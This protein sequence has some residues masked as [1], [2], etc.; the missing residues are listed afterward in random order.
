MDPMI[1]FWF[2]A[3]SV[4]VQITIAVALYHMAEQRFSNGALWAWIGILFGPLALLVY[5]AYVLFDASMEKAR[6]TAERGRL[7]RFMTEYRQERAGSGE[8]A[9]GTTGGD[10]HVE[11]LLTDGRY[12]AARDHVTERLRQAHE[13]GDQ[14]REDIYR[15]YLQQI[16]EVAG[17]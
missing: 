6:E 1:L 17:G 4:T 11:Q 7:E 8:G 3:I 10:P 16:D 2:W 15:G 5:G 13:M 9:R 12:A 14:T